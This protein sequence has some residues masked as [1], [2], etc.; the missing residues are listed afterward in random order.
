M[1]MK[2][3]ILGFEGG[4]VLHGVVRNLHLGVVWNVIGLIVH[5]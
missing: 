2:L 5:A 3:C 4:F 1:A